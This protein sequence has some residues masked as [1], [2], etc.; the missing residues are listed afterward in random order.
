MRDY[1]HKKIEPEIQKLWEK[2]GL[3]KTPE[4]P[5]A[6]RK[7][8]V[9]DMF[10]YPSGA[11]LHV[12]HVEGYTATD[13]YS[14]F[15]RM[16][17]FDVMHPMGWD[18]FGLPAENYA[19]KTGIHPSETTQKAVD[20]F[21]LQI[22]KLGLSYDWSREL[23]T[24]SQEY[25][26]WTQWLFL[27]F[28][29]NGL[30]YKK[31]AAVNWCPGCQTVLANEQVVDGFCERCGTAVVKKDMEQWFFNI[32]RYS[33]E[34]IK[35]LDTID[36][37]E[38]TKAAQRNWVGK[39]E[40]AEIIFP[41]KKSFN[42]VLVH[43]FAGGSDKHFIPWLKEELESRENSVVIPALPNPKEPNVEEQIEFLKKEVDFTEDTIVV[44][45]S[46]GS[47]VALK[48]IESLS[49]K[50]QKL[51]LVGGF[52][53]ANIHSDKKYFDTFNWNFDFEKI[54]KNVH[55]IV[56][57][58]DG[59]DDVIPHEQAENL[60][61]KLGGLLVHTQATEPHFRSKEEDVVLR[62]SL[63]G[64][65]AFTTRPD[66]LFGATY[67]V[68]APEHPLI[69]AHKRDIK[70][71][72]E[73]EGYV[74][75]A[76]NKSDVERNAQGKDKTGVKI[77]GVSVINPGTGKPIP[78]YVAD[79][80]LPGYGS[81]AIMAVPA[82]DERDFEFAKAFDLPII[83]VVDGEGELP[84]GQHGALVNSGVFTGLVSDEAKSQIV[85]H[86]GGVSKTVYRLRDWLVSRQRYWGAPIPI[87][88]DP[89]GIPHAI[90]EEHLPW[91]LP[92]DVDYN[93]KGTAPLGSSKELRERTEK[94]F[95]KGW[96]PEI[97]T[98]DTFVDS[99]WY[100]LRFT[101]PHNTNV[102]AD[103]KKIKEWLPVD[104][105]VGGA[106]HSVLHLL[107]ARFF[108][109][110]LRDLGFLNIDEPFT[111]LR[112][113][114]MILG[115]DGEKMSKSK[116]NIV[117][118]D[119]M[120][121]RFGADT[122]RV[123]E[124]FMGPFNQA[125]AWSIDN[126]VGVRR[127]I[128]KVWR[129]HEKVSDKVSEESG[130]MAKTI[131]KVSE[132]IPEFRLNTVVSALMICANAFEKKEH[133]ATKDYRTFLQLLAPLAPHITD[134]LWRELGEKQSIHNSAWPTYDESALEEEVESY[135]VQVNGKVRDTITVDVGLKDEEIFELAR[136]E[137]VEKW[138]DGGEVKRAIVVRGKIVSFVV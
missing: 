4:N 45:H 40:G 69:A 122:L 75:L 131:K 62:A 10:P 52:L 20:N 32:T 49:H 93:P 94:I 64:I 101:D 8:Y 12:G 106:E 44:A 67:M 81:G 61:Q 39:S 88:Y 66:T 91:K 114:G 38:S 25:F 119:D 2:E 68:L 7:R 84:R 17:G 9:L 123:Y 70:N 13:I 95:G 33:D 79:Y 85:A 80:V 92:I 27:L 53:D 73:V 77:E 134:A 105:Y 90:P 54:K 35:D 42:Y 99:S 18:A 29:K 28:Y 121:E 78:V 65:T 14:R 89:D 136:T 86:V 87:V 107:Y 5:K 71:I 124:M 127:F 83:E 129:L 100:F 50:I 56:I 37:P 76:K 22:N 103:Q 36:W 16:S 125:K 30:A 47:V 128:E 24:S 117:N 19:V 104:T 41:M 96:T 137:K 23:N 11:G 138:I 113:Q 31:K 110:A 6:E 130:L 108:T 26:K 111:R 43:G 72:Q 102:F 57:L 60:E 21:T 3:Y 34:L 58:H 82:H 120:I 133:I 46:L 48:A 109:K 15:L 59:H 118:P 98:M 55:E 135:A 115:P 74:E 63:A 126:M 51:V 132:D 1:E 116:G 112:H 97:D